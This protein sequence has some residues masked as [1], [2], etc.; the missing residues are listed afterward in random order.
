MR[1]WRTHPG[2]K[3]RPA[4]IDWILTP[5][6]SRVPCRWPFVGRSPC[7]IRCVGFAPDG[8][9]ANRPPARPGR[10]RTLLRQQR[11]G[12][13][14]TRFSPAEP[15][16]G[17]GS[18]PSRFRLAIARLG[19]SDQ[20]IDESSRRRGN[21]LHGAIKRRAV[22]LGRTVE[23]AEFP[24]ELQGRGPNLRIR[25]GRLK[26]EKRLDVS[27]H[28]S[29]L[30]VGSARLA[31][32]RIPLGP[33]VRATSSSK[34]SWSKG[35]GCISA[36]YNRRPEGGPP[37]GISLSLSLSCLQHPGRGPQELSDS[38]SPARPA[39]PGRSAPERLL[40]EPHHATSKTLDFLDASTRAQRRC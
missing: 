22:G 4:R 25:R 9:R 20:R 23:T 14:Q 2:S 15:F 40:G 19:C 24:D 5:K 18:C 39:R 1:A 10:G 33:P 35:R 6:A 30:P 17:P 32:V 38:S 11:R 26:V 37:R 16:C 29:W 28:D 3:G 36:H 21:F 31:V 34:A 13:R 7:L 27:A 12:E 8:A